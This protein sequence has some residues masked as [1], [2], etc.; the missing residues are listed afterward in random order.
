MALCNEAQVKAL[1]DWLSTT[2]PEAQTLKLFTNNHTPAIGD[3]ASDYTEAATAG[4]VAKSLARATWNGA[5]VSGGLTTKT[6]PIQTF[7]FTG[8][9]TIYG[10]YIVGAS[11]G[12]VYGAE[13]IY[14]TGQAFANTDQM[15]ITPK[16]GLV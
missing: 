2:T 12:K 15:S 8:N 4:Y 7:T 11:S 5:S 16:V 10:Y 14:P 9:I 13:L 3:T 6:Y 1:D